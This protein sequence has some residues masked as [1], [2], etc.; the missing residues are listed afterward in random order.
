MAKLS[1]AKRTRGAPA[2]TSLVHQFSTNSHEAPLDVIHEFEHSF[3]LLLRVTVQCD[4]TL[5]NGPSVQ[6]SDACGASTQVSKR[7][8]KVPHFRSMRPAK[9]S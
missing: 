9:S 1:C 3:H 6:A 7:F 2:A 4:E 8:E 5:Q